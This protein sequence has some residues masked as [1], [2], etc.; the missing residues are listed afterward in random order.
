M[1]NAGLAVLGCVMWVS[2]GLAAGQAETSRDR[3]TWPIPAH[4]WGISSVVAKRCG[5]TP[6]I[7]DPGPRT[8]AL[9]NEAERA[10]GNWARAAG[11]GPKRVLA[12][13]SRRRRQRF[14]GAD[15]RLMAQHG[16]TCHLLA[17]LGASWSFI[18][19]F[20]HHG[21]TQGVNSGKYRACTVPTCSPRCRTLACH[22]IVSTWRPPS[23]NAVGPLSHPSAW[24]RHRPGL[25]HNARGG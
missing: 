7:L 8:Q 24:A 9:G 4:R 19:F 22:S 3:P 2:I 16:A 25:T 21:Q 17:P 18:A 20:A 14:V 13:N 6:R 5:A 11:H 1:L 12:W 23:S 10:L 15:L